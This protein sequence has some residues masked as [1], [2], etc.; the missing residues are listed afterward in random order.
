MSAMKGMD[1]GVVT[2]WSRKAAGTDLPQV[3]QLI[4]KLCTEATGLPWTGSD[5]DSFVSNEVAEVQQKL[6]L[7]TAAINQMASTAGK[8]ASEQETTSAS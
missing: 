2:E 6:T 1:T 3:E 5:F 4:S 7:L 8:N